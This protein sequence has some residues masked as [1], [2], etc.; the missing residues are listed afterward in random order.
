VN[1][2]VRIFICIILLVLCGWIFAAEMAPVPLR[3]SREEAIRMAIVKNPQVLAAQEQAEQAR[4]RITEAKALPDLTFETTLEQQ[5]NFFHPRSATTED[6]GI[7]F[8]IPFP[9]KLQI[10]GKV[11]TTE[12]NSAKLNVVLTRN[13]IAAQT[14]QA[15][16]ALLVA[17]S[18]EQILTDGKNLSQDFLNKTQGRYEA[19]TVP[20]L[21]TIK[22]KV[23]LVLAENDIIANERTI[24]TARATLNRL[25]ARPQGGPIEISETLEIPPPLAELDALEKLALASRP[26]ILMNASDLQGA[27]F[28]TNLA[29]KYW[30]P[31]FSITL[32]KNFTAGS[33]SAYTT[34]G[35]VSLPFLLF[36]QHRNGEIAE[37]RHRE[38]ELAATANDL[39]A[40]VSLDVRTAYA[41]ASTA[42][43]QAIYI[44]DELIPEAKEAF[45]IA[46]TSYSLGGS[47]ALDL[48][49]AKR[50]MLDAQGQYA[51]AMGAA[52]DAIAD[53]EKAVGAP[54]L[55]ATGGSHDQ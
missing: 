50:T 21:D 33:P 28:A 12:L 53:L 3:I 51:D 2:I 52:N 25:L 18:H 45:Q 16:D 7:G 1:Q 30:L 37:A 17:L 10:A 46:S 20:R 31:D 32:S 24:A 36:W 5:D 49:D 35:S 44:R 11:A 15:Y 9:S 27:S 47:S 6:Y 19:G 55:P 4:A 40:Q 29:S 42:I 39:A 13:E 23:D 8:T 54:L 41:T 38:A 26:E 34:A 48:L 22:A 43:R 14:A